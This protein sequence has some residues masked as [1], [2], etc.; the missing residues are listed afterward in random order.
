MANIPD[1]IGPKGRFRWS[2]NRR[3]Q[4]NRASAPSLDDWTFLDA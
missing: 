1:R 2:S 3:E 4:Q